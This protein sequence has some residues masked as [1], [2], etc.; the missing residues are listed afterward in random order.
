[1]AKQQT[2]S[3]QKTRTRTEEPRRYRVILHND[4][5][6]TMEF[7]VM[8]LKV[9]FFKSEAEAETLMLTVHKKGKAVAGIYP[10]D[11]ALSKTNKATQMAKQAGFPLKITC[12]PED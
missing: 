6:T 7:V 8:M 11:I 4:D 2:L 10:R 5:F 3:V 1:M 9:V 12:E